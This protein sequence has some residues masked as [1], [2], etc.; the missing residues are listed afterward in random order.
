MD[1]QRA[2]AS[3][4]EAA[5]LDDVGDLQQLYRRIRPLIRD[6]LATEGFFS[7]EIT[8]Q[9]TVGGQV[10]FEKQKP[11]LKILVKTGKVSIVKQVNVVFEGDLAQPTESNL[12]RQVDLRALWTLSEGQ[13]FTQAQWDA[14]KR[15]VL[16]KLLAKDYAAATLVSSLADVD[17]EQGEVWLTVVYDSGPRF[18]FGDLKVEGLSKY[19][20]DLVTR[21]ATIRPGDAY[22]QEKLLDLLGELQGTAYFSAVD[23]KFDP[24]VDQPLMTPVQVTVTESDTRRLGLGGGYSS[25]TGFRSEVSWTDTNVFDRAY[26]LV[27]GVRLEQKRQSAFADLFLPPRNQ[28]VVD[29]LGV[30]VDH[31]DINNLQVQ[32]SA[33]GVVRQLTLADAEVKLGVNF[34]V[35]DRLAQG[36]SLGGLKALVASA[37]WNRNRVDDKL[38]PTRGYVLNAQ[39]AVASKAALSDQDFVRLNGK[40]Q[41][42]FSPSRQSLVSTRLELGTV[43][44]NSEQTIP[45]DYLYRA[46]GTGSLRGFKFLGVGVENAGVVQGG[47]RL[48]LGSVEYTRWLREP[49]GVAVFT[50]VGDVA[51]SWNQLDVKAAVGG[52]VRYRT[53]AGPVAFDIAKAQG[54]SRPRIHFALGVAF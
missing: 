30:S 43:L 19:P 28:G 10:Q 52:G 37:A 23:V 31:Q 45:Q 1:V 12:M 4:V 16:N 33:V 27:S 17:A 3:T 13:A 51:N 5:R 50:D 39:S 20:K 34:Q 53:P 54:E 47:R 36:V 26:S 41:H 35:E 38:N 7:P 42:Y 6:V 18:T 8:L 14:S 29:S 49:L 22:D 46:G 32:R 11:L 48:L 21:Y 9:N 40:V 24:K 15:A 44:A 2:I 25:N